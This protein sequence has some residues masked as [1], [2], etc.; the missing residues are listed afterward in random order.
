[1]RL[2]ILECTRWFS[3]EL[4]PNHAIVLKDEGIQCEEH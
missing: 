4:G 2:F 1:V 3:I